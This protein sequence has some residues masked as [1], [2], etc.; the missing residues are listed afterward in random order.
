M[1]ICEPT[2]SFGADYMDMF[3]AGRSLRHGIGLAAVRREKV[4]A[5]SR[6]WAAIEMKYSQTYNGVWEKKR[7]GKG[8][9]RSWKSV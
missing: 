5:R 3:D 2:A 4:P 1:E 6:K 7:G 9:C 8:R